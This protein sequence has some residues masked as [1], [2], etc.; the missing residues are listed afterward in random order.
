MNENAGSADQ[1]ELLHESMGAHASVTC[2]RTTEK[3]HGIELAEQAA[4]A[5][6]DVVAAAG[7]DGI[8]AEVVNALLRA[9]GRRRLGVSRLGP[10][11]DLPRIRDSAL[12]DAAAALYV[13]ET[14][15][16]RWLDPY[17]MTTPST[18]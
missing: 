5:G 15:V 1:A 10:G 17:W 3:G 7:S 4:R 9:D 12:K 8:I 2:R 18:S 16:R 11:N 6:F 13:S 14:G